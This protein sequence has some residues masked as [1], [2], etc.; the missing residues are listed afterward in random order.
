MSLLKCPK[1]GEMFSDSYKECPFCMDDEELYQEGR[2]RSR[3]RRVERP[4]S[5][6]I[7]GPA[8]L[9]V[10]LLLVAFLGYTFL[11]D[12]IAALF[13]GEEKPPVV[14]PSNDPVDDPVVKD[15]VTIT[16][17]QTTLVLQAGES[18]V[19]TATGADGVKWTSSDPAVATVDSTGKITALSAGSV[20]VTASAENAKS[21]VCVLTV[22]PGAQKDIE[23]VT[24]WGASLW[25]PNEAFS[26][27][28]GNSID[29][30][31]DGT[32]ATPSWEIDDT[33]I[34]TVDADGVVTGVSSG[35]AV[36]TVKVDGQTIEIDVT[37][38]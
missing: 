6:Q 29:L 5:P 22:M 16:L 8:M 28:A 32:D 17:D 18:A 21:A 37:V 15:P 30:D 24:S 12:Q 36:L 33:E 31:V 13:Q 10:V 38:N 7:A 14:D 19:L 2:A 3:G 9:V 25:A 11:G 20:T 23:V 4:K 27:G 34:A 1:C 35:R 26:V